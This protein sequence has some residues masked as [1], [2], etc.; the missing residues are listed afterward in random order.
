MRADL[1]ANAYNSRLDSGIL[2]TLI[3]NDTVI[4]INPIR[5]DCDAI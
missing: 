1:K 2:S 4:K 3:D 5:I